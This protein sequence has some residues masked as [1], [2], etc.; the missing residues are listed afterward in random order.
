MSVASVSMWITRISAFVAL[1]AVFNYFL[2]FVLRGPLLYLLLLLSFI[3]KEG[4]TLCFLLL[5]GKILVV[6]V[7]DILYTDWGMSTIPV[8]EHRQD[9][10]LDILILVCLLCAIFF[11]FRAGYK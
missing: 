7:A 9:L 5:A 1:C 11:D 8:L 6:S 10:L 2:L 4:V 3:L